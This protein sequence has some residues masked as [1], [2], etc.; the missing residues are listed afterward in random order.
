MREEIKGTSREKRRMEKGVRVRGREWWR[1]DRGR[2]KKT[3]SPVFLLIQSPDIL[4]IL[5]L[6]CR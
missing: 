3:L 1:G 2:G 4:E 5:R 6:K